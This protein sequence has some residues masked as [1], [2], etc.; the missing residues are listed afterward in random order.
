M[1]TQFKEEEFLPEDE[2]ITIIQ[3]LDGSDLAV[4]HHIL[5]LDNEEEQYKR[6]RSMRCIITSYP[7][8]YNAYTARVLVTNP[9]YYI[10]NEII[11]RYKI[12]FLIY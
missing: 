7:T 3:L 4:L 1:D 6:L 9:N 2:F 8:L 11:R 5:L 12:Q 10:T